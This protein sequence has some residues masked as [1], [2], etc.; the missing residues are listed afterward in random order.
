MPRTLAA[1]TALAVVLS[2]APVATGSEQPEE[3]TSSVDTMSS[4]EKGS[5]A[6]Q[7]VTVITM[8]IATAGLA[9]ALAA[10]VQGTAGILQLAPPPLP[11]LVQR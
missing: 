11:Q 6:A 4:T 8:V 9:F 1:G 3:A 7:T 10:L 2:L 5:P